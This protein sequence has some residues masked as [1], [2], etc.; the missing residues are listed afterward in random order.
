MIHVTT[1][2][3]LVGIIFSKLKHIND[4]I[5]CNSIYMK[6][7]NR[8]KKKRWRQKLGQWLYMGEVMPPRMK[9]DSL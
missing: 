9:K 1:W 3:N 7:K 2:M 5:P 4:N 8:Q 6:F